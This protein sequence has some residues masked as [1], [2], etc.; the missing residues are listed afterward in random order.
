MQ[1]KY[2]SQL[3]DLLLH[4]L[5]SPNPRVRLRAIEMI[6]NYVQGIVDAEEEV[7]EQP[8]GVK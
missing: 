3:C 5:Q 8:G 7:V 6:T 1:Q 2:S 4:G